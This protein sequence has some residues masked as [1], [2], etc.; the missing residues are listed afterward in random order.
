MVHE[1]NDAA[2]F[3]QRFKVSKSGQYDF[4][5]SIVRA[6]TVPFN[7]KIVSLACKGAQTSHLRTWANSGKFSATPARW[8]VCHTNS[9]M[10]LDLARGMSGRNLGNTTLKWASCGHPLLS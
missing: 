5:M 8:F 2:C 3:G 4:E 7:V 9:M 10:Q 1:Q 6:R